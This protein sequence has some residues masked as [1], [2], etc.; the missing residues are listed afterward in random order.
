MRGT[1]I[2]FQ[3]AVGLLLVGGPRAWSQEAASEKNP[4][5]SP[6]AGTKPSNPFSG[7]SKPKPKP[8]AKTETP[9][10]EQLVEP[11][12]EPKPEK[13]AEPAPDQPQA[14]EPAGLQGG[15]KPDSKWSVVA[16]KASFSPLANARFSFAV[17][18]LLPNT[19][20]RWERARMRVLFPHLP[21]AVVGIGLNE[22]DSDFREI[23]DIEN[24][25]KLGAVSQLGLEGSKLMAL[26][27]D[28]KYFA[29]KP[30]FDDVIVIVDVAS[31][32]T[33]KTLAIADQRIDLVAFSSGSQLILGEN[34]RVLKYPLPDAKPQGEIKI[35]GW[36][37]RDGWQ[38]S[39]GGKY[40]AAVLRDGSERNRL[41]FYDLAGGELAGELIL[42]GGKGDCTGIAFSLDG[43]SLA[44]VIDTEADLMLEVFDLTTPAVTA[45]VPVDRTAVEETDNYQGPFVEWLPGG[46]RLLIAGRSVVD[47]ATGKIDETISDA[48]S[49]AI[50][51]LSEGVYAA[52]DQ[53]KFVARAFGEVEE[54]SVAANTASPDPINPPTQPTEPAEASPGPPLTSANRS[55]IREVSGG[56]VIRW[57]VRLEAPPTY[58]D[59]LISTPLKVPGGFVQQVLMSSTDPPLAVVSYSSGP[60]SGRASQG[61][62]TWVETFDL[63]SGLSRNTVN[64]TL[65]VVAVGVTADGT[66]VATVTT[67]DLGRIDVW[68]LQD[69]RHV[70]GFRPAS[71][72]ADDL[73]PW[74]VDFINAEN[75]IVA[76]GDELTMW[77]LP[78][79]KAVY[80]MRIGELRP[81]M[82]PGR[83]H[84]AVSVPGDPRLLVVE[85]LTGETRGSVSTSGMGGE[86]PTAAAFHHRGR[87]LAC[88]TSDPSG[89][90]LVVVE[91]AG[92]DSTVR[93]RLPV[94]GKVLQWCGDDHLLIDG[95]R[96]VSLT[97]EA[98]VWNYDISMGIHCRE[99]IEGRHWYLT[100]ISPNDKSYVLFGAG[101]PEDTSL[102][103]ISSTTLAKDVVFKPGDP[104]RLEVVADGAGPK[105]AAGQILD[106]LTKRY[107]KAGSAAT[108]DAEAVLR[109][110][111]YLPPAQRIIRRPATS[112]LGHGGAAAGHGPLSD[113]DLLNRATATAQPKEAV[114]PPTIPLSNVWELSLAVG[115]EIVWQTWLTADPA[116]VT[117][118]SREPDAAARRDDDPQAIRMAVAGLLSLEP[119]KYAFS[120]GASDGAGRSLLSTNGPRKPQQ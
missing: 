111:P 60:L 71:G 100:A 54:P 70:A 98:V 93:T 114:P 10:P 105:T 58:K 33:T 5:K 88:L 35:D 82:S 46:K 104:I 94:S 102:R 21:G 109:V 75:L 45:E 19:D 51:P 89:G 68:S 74:F 78:E 27:P 116:E 53:T 30:Q 37:V 49:Y 6:P 73:V 57:D 43:R 25:R 67:G 22:K 16:D 115:N 12:V 23:W 28:G 63:Q 31:G 59:K 17:P 41:S 107:A 1:T 76:I 91:T 119:P 112:A 96:L 117:L 38:L 52:V 84:F 99:S 55:G 72:A 47:A 97:S 29:A 77:K 69:D 66:R 39:P 80:S 32:R 50:R 14:E 108:A 20:P 42:T 40:F 113:I 101:L 7:D 62:K 56:A 86:R 3:V 13:P 64:F 110:Q 24:I 9:E 4:F 95:T 15:V 120:T 85:S 8:P 65:P 26:S 44:A 118:L 81:A 2:L 34:G 61:A 18:G 83:D 92:G 87:W 79:C 48:G 11:K 36:A 106:S 90:E 103:K